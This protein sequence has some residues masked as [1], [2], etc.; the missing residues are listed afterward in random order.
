MEIA[1]FIT[2]PRPTGETNLLVA[3]AVG[4]ANSGE[5][6]REALEGVGLDPCGDWVAVNHGTGGHSLEAEARAIL[7]YAKANDYR[8]LIVIGASM[9]AGVIT[10][11]EDCLADDP[12]HYQ[13]VELIG[14]VYIDPMVK[15]RSLKLIPHGVL[16]LGVPAT[17]LLPRSFWKWKLV[18][19][20]APVVEEEAK[21]I[22]ARHVEFMGDVDP[23]TRRAQILCL[24]N[25]GRRSGLSARQRTTTTI[26]LFCEYGNDRFL[27]SRV[28]E[29][30]L[31]RIYG[32]NFLKQRYVPGAYHNSFADQPRLWAE[33]INSAVRQL[34][35]LS[36]FKPMG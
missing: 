27:R 14:N 20:P 21:Q 3:V 12:E 26:L 13:S 35:A 19:G 28:A 8:R 9:G 30:L 10:A 2:G 5:I 34:K 16:C 24:L 29:R 17:F 15:A 36:E 6:V 33:R 11:V 22:S 23:K 32:K 1:P 7:D 18:T 31:C 25:F 4:I